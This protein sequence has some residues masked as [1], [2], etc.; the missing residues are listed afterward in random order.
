MTSEELERSFNEYAASLTGDGKSVL[1]AFSG[2]ADSV[3]LLHLLQKYC[4]AHRI[5][6]YA[7]HVNHLIR[8]DEA[9]CD[10]SFCREFCEKSGTELFV[11]RFDVPALAAK[12][13][14]GLEE[15][16]RQVRY[17]YFDSLCRNKQ[18]DLVATAH[19]ATDNIETVLFNLARGAGSEGMSG[20][21]LKRGN[22]VRPLLFAPKSDI[23]NYCEEKG[24][25]FVTDS[26]NSDTAYTRNF[27]RHELVPQ[28]KRINPDA[29]GAVS[30]ACAQ[31][32]RDNDYLKGEAAKYSLSSGRKI[33][34]SLDDAILSRVL[35]RELEQAGGT[36]SYE[37]ITEMA[38]DVRSDKTVSD[39]SVP[40]GIT[41]RCERGTV[42]LLKLTENSGFNIPLTDGENRL[43][44]GKTVIFM[45]IGKADKKILKKLDV[46]KNIYKLS[47]YTSFNSDKMNGKLYIRN[48][49]DG[50]R[51][52]Y[53]GIN[54]RVK[55]L[56]RS[57]K[58]PLEERDMLPFICDGGGILWI[59]GFPIRDGMKPEKEESTANIWFFRNRA[60]DTGAQSIAE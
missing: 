44:D 21:P 26:T 49:A 59:P 10:E 29:E 23:L 34:A 40:G 41:F 48:R 15:T 12:T 56:L 33:L 35:A 53:G 52:R 42:K 22:I 2:G 24:L 58:V 9:E 30:R 60:E 27:I 19:N 47:I 54:R 18:I 1:A 8:G 36:P 11:L 20:I 39:R 25:A 50:D 46:L 45:H 57:A 5:R 51:Y 4:T 43:P 55:E 31:L 17:D 14:K 3:T 7:A 28:L 16:A 13:G 38:G 6:L 37:R 32:R